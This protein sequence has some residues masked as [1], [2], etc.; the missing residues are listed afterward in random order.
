MAP[1]RSTVC[2]SIAWF[3]RPDGLA[4]RTLSIRLFA[5]QPLVA[6]CGEGFAFKWPPVTY[7]GGTAIFYING[8][9]AGSASGTLGPVTTAALKIG[10]SGDCATFAG[11]IDE[12]SIYNRALSASEVQAICSAGSGGKCVSRLL[13]P[14][15]TTG[16]FVVRILG[17]PFLTYTLE[18]APLASGPWAKL[19]NMTVPGVDQ[20]LGLGIIQF[21]E[22]R[23]PGQGRFYR[24][25]YPA[26]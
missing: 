18:A 23:Q 5:L 16:S 15:M 22:P 25:V 14:A 6:E 21:S 26:Y 9:A 1:R 2:G 13:N 24:T 8:Q 12:V 17:V 11:L 10:G 4:I 3:L 19:G 7:D 20:G